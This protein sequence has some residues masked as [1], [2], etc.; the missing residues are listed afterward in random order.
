MDPSRR[1]AKLLDDEAPRKRIPAAVVFGE[2]KVKDV[3]VMDRLTIMARDP[4]DVQVE[5]LGSI[6]AVK[7]LPVLFDSLA[8]VVGCDQKGRALRASGRAQVVTR[9]WLRRWLMPKTR[10][11]GKDEDRQGGR[12]TR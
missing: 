4:I 8:R 9:C 10:R 7:A 1:I 2:L 5:A 12:R 6:R 11:A 3:G